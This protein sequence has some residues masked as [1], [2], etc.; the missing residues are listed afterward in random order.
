MAGSAIQCAIGIVRGVVQ[1]RGVEQHLARPLVGDHDPVAP[2]RAGGARADIDVAPAHDD[3][4]ASEHRGVVDAEAL[5]LQV[6]CLRDAKGRDV[7]ALAEAT[8]GD[9]EER[10]A[11]VNA[12]HE[13]D[14]TY[15]GLPGSPNEGRRAREL[16]AGLDGAIGG[17]AAI[18]DARVQR[19]ARGEVTDL[20]CLGPVAVWCAIAQIA[21]VPLQVHGLAGRPAAGRIHRETGRDEV[22]IRR[23]DGGRTKGGSVVRLGVA[24]RVLFTDGVVDVGGDD[25]VQL[26]GTARPVGELH[27]RAAEPRRSGREYATGRREVERGEDVGNDLA[28]GHPP[29]EHALAEVGGHVTIAGVGRAPLHLDGRP[30]RDRSGGR[31]RL[32]IGHLQVGARLCLEV[33]EIDRRGCRR[34]P[35]GELVGVDAAAV[36]TAALQRQ[37]VVAGHRERALIGIRAEACLEH[38]TAQRVVQPPRAIPVGDGLHVEVELLARVHVEAVEVR[39]VAGVQLAAHHSARCQHRR[40]GEVEH[41][42]RIGAGLLVRRVDGECV[43]AG[44]E[45]EDAAAVP[46][47]GGVER[48]IGHQRAQRTREVPAEIVGDET[49]D[50]DPRLLRHRERVAVHLPR[51]RDRAVDARIEGHGHEIVGDG[52]DIEAVGIGAGRVT[53]PFQEQRVRAVERQR[54][55][56]AVGEA[57]LPYEAAERI[58]Q[59]PRTVAVGDRLHVEVEVVAGLGLETVEG[60]AVRRVEHPRHGCPGREGGRG[61]EIHEAEAVGARAVAVAVDGDPVVARGQ[62]E[63]GDAIPRIG[64]RERA[65]RHQRA[66]RTGQGPV[67]VGVGERIEVEL[68][69]AVERERVRIHLPDVIDRAVDAFADHQRLRVVDDTLDV[70]PV[71]IGARRIAP[72]FQRDRVVAREAER[73]ALH[74][75]P[76]ADLADEATERIV[77]PPRTIAVR[78]RLH[79]EVEGLAG[80]GGKAVEIGLVGRAQRARHRSPGRDE[81]RV[82]EVEQSQRVAADRA[83]QPELVGACD[84]VEHVPAFPAVGALQADPF[85]DDATLAGKR[86]LDRRVGERVDHD[87]LVLGQREEIGVD[88]AVGG[89]RAGDQ[90]IE[91]DRIPGEIGRRVADELDDESI[92][93]RGRRGVAPAFQ[94]QG[95]RAGDRQPDGRDVGAHPREEH[96]PAERIDQPPVGVAIRQRL[97]VEIEDVAGVG[98]DLVEVGLVRG[99]KRSRHGN[100]GRDQRGSGQIAQEER[101]GADVVTG[102]VDGERVVPCHQ[103]EHRAGAAEVDGVRV[104]KGATGRDRAA[105]T[106]EAPREVAVRLRIEHHPRALGDGEREAVHL[107]GRGDAA[108]HQRVERYRC[109]VIRDGHD[110]E[111]ER[112]DRAVVIP[113]LDGDQVAAGEGQG[114]GVDV[115]REVRGEHHPAQR[116]DEAP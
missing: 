68:L 65:L 103:V 86:P 5:D 49:V 44:N 22:G 105:R 42:E 57:L 21:H 75:R 15:A 109:R 115:V 10:V 88:L 27:R 100:A 87:T 37:H 99:G 73:H 25:E 67:D 82:R 61:R 104:L 98:D 13:L 38:E 69:R 48:A 72:A 93:V 41:T 55:A 60:G 53:A 71:G 14:E 66:A 94:H 89:D 112:I 31:D 28:G 63:P 19:L 29:D 39:L 96:L 8:R 76:Q 50:V 77:E 101:V 106:G 108:G 36:V 3:N 18:E 20:D 84:Q 62:I 80:G 95:V 74:V 40:R 91:R 45:I 97:V 35:Y 17:N 114:H 23:Q 78:H 11:T 34:W 16:C 33:A 26:A 47:V 4:I 113:A 12:D 30:G 1:H 56:V 83:L 81:R 110:V 92:V 32:E 107:T 7:V 116:I 70:E 79:V 90:R 24:H 58:E 43:G 64:T 111:S 52:H 2:A 46:A 102:R 54:R 51:H 6:R 59:P 9:L 85:G